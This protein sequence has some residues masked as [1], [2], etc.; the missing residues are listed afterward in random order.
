MSDHVGIASGHL[1]PA[2]RVRVLHVLGALNPGG[3]ETWLMHVLRR[4]DR[5]RLQMDFLVHRLDR[6]VFDDEVEA[7]GSRIFRCPRSHRRPWGYAR[8]FRRLLAAHGPYD[9][10][11][12]HVHHFSGVVLQLARATGVERRIAHSHSDTRATQLAAPWRRRLYYRTMRRSLQ[13]AATLKLATSEGAAEALFGP[14]WRSDPGARIL[15]CGIDLAPFRSP[16]DRA[17]VRREL[18][19]PA[20]TFVVGHVGRFE[21]PKNHPFLIELTRRLAAQLP[22]TRLVLVGDGRRRAVV[23]HAVARAGLGSRAIFTGVRGDVARIMR[24]AFDVFVFPSLL[25]GLGLAVLEAQAA[26]LPAVVSTGVPPEAIVVPGLV[27]RLALASGVDA[28]AREVLGARA[29]TRVPQPD[30]LAALEASSFDVVRSAA[31][32]FRLY[33]G[34]TC[35][36]MGSQQPAPSDPR[37]TSCDS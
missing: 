9:V 4:A 2:E 33:A 32:L 12:S 31:S 1:P 7:L 37:M 24:G 14:C 22:A 10:V 16:V 15:P 20:D 18:G 30:A 21:E 3:V 8:A 5:A 25:E 29:A 11:H 17:E 27:K 35:P 13:G 23:E 36:N 26:G 28:W 19:I 34:E 6:G